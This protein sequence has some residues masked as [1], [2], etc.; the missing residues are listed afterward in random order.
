ML[1]IREFLTTDVPYRP[2]ELDVF[3]DESQPNWATFDPDTGYLLRS[4]VKR[5]GM[6]DCYTIGT[7][8]PSGP[9][10]GVNYATD[11]CRIHTYG[12]SF[13]QCHQVSD[14]ETWQE[15]LAAH[16]GEPIRNFGV[17]GFGVYQAFLRLGRHEAEGGADHVILNIFPDDHFRSVDSW[18]WLRIEPFRREVRE[19]DVH[20]LH[21]TPWKHLRLDP[22]TGT[23]EER[24]SLAPTREAL[25]RL[26]RPEEVFELLRDDLIVHLEC[27]KAGGEYSE[28]IVA[29]A[30]HQLGRPYEGPEDLP[31]IHQAYALASTRALLPRVRDF[32]EARG[33]R[34]LVVFSYGIDQIVEYCDE[35][36]RFDEDLLEFVRASG[37]DHIDTLEAHRRD[38]ADYRVSA[39]DYA[40]RF[41][42]YGFGHYN[43]MGNMF[44][45]MALREPLLRWIDPLPPTY[46]GDG[47]SFADAAGLLN[48]GSGGRGSR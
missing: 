46:R 12:D 16:F 25:Y 20:Y 22:E 11:P 2:A 17:G 38:F 45:A 3:F 4:C 48:Y 28:E 42:V 15:H 33:K 9:R 35:G 37:F 47:P 21:A 29:A 14:G 30:A 31:E 6:D 41:F 36:T 10:K 40:R 34:L 27:G 18:R 8:A 32:V 13:T 43:P 39:L 44:F 5:D 19:R 1:T 23:F 7:Y 26:C 24:P